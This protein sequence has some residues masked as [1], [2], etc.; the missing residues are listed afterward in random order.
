MGSFEISRECFVVMTH[1]FI[2]LWFL[3]DI[4]KCSLCVVVN[5]FL[6]EGDSMVIDLLYP[7]LKKHL[8]SNCF[9]HCLCLQW[10]WHL[11]ATCLVAIDLLR[12]LNLVT[13]QRRMMVIP[14]CKLLILP[15]TFTYCI[16][17]AQST[18][19]KESIGDK[20]YFC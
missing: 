3:K 20:L 4:F 10:Q 1:W 18:I 8:F 9:N 13:L 7:L 16:S 2:I 14:S 15:T 12:S 17:F 6:V 11:M 19:M 5:C